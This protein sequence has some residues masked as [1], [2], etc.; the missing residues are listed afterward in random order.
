ME[1]GFLKVITFSV[2][3][4]LLALPFR[5]VKE[6]VEGTAGVRKMPYGVKALKGIL[7][8][9][10]R[11][12]SVICTPFVLGMAEKEEE[13]FVL[14]CRYGEGKEVVGLTV[15]GVKGLKVVNLSAVT[16]QEG[17]QSPF[18]DGLFIE[19]KGSGAVA[20]SIL[21][22]ERFLDGALAMIRETDH[23]VHTGGIFGKETMGRGV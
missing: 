3:G 5:E 2:G 22:L 8:F 1:L 12:V 9:E 7:S 17:G 13:N 20:V 6:I 14:L 11:L 18:T 16:P 23:I 4:S 21:N 10:G 19:G 15:S